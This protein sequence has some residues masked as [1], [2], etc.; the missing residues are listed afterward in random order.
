[1][2]HFL[3]IFLLL[4]FCTGCGYRFGRGDFVEKYSTISIPY[5]EG[6]HD[7][8]LTGE[9]IHKISARGALRYVKSGG[10][11][12]LTVCLADPNDENIGFTYV[13][14]NE[15]VLTNILAANEARLTLV[16]KISVIE[17]C[18]GRTVIGPVHVVSSLTYDFEPDYRRFNFH[19]FALGQ[20]EVHNLA[21]DA[22]FRPVYNDLAQKIVDYVSYSW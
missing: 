5:V 20:L 2:K 8:I 9:I 12:I 13:K 17:A 11:L 22:A 1:M 16:A 14:N 7:G 4:I 21:E 6:D 15:G 18:S 19:N 10:D 3:I